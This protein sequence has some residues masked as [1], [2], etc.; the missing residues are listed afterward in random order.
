MKGTC[1]IFI[2][3]AVL[4]SCRTPNETGNPSTVITTGSESTGNWQK[5]KDCATQSKS[6]MDDFERQRRTEKFSPALDWT[7]HYSPKYDQCFV[8]ATYLAPNTGGERLLIL[9][10]TPILRGSSSL[11]RQN[12]IYRKENSYVLAAMCSPPR[13]VYTSRGDHGSG[14]KDPFNLAV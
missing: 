3:A 9:C 13:R 1:I 5:P 7:N 12:R 11:S 4:L 6:V 14:A 10:D 8:E 2:A